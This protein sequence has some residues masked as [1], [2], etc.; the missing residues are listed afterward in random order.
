MVDDFSAELL[1]FIQKT[2]DE[3]LLGEVCIPKKRLFDL[4]NTKFPLNMEKYRFELLLT[5]AIK[6]NRIPG[7]E[8]RQGRNGGVCRCNGHRQ[9]KRRE[10]IAI[11]FKGKTF[12]VQESKRAFISHLIHF[13]TEGKYGSGNLFINN[14]LY[15]IPEQLDTLTFL[16]NYLNTGVK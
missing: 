14:K 13:C 3:L 16:E 6:M 5:K 1:L 15:C 10:S 12:N 4:I 11:S 9:T 7:Y 2:L 8:I